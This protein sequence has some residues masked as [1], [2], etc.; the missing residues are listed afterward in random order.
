MLARRMLN[1]DAANSLPSLCCG[2]VKFQQNEWTLSMYVLI[3]T[4]SQETTILLQIH[5]SI[6]DDV[7]VKVEMRGQKKMTQVTVM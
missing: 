6:K 7:H 2:L 5:E 1:G 3:R 4:R